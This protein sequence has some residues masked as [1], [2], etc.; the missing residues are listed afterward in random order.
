MNL[1]YILAA[2]IR[3]LFPETE[4]GQVVAT[5]ECF[6]CDVHFS[7]NFNSAMLSQLEERMRA[8]ACKEISL[9]ELTM[10]PTNAAQ[11]LEHHGDKKLA[12]KVRQEE[13]EVVLVQLDRFFF[14]SDG[15]VRIEKKPFFKLVCFWPH[16]QGVRILGVTAS[17]KEELKEQAQ[18]IK[19][20]QNP[21]HL[22]EE[23]K[24]VS[25]L[26]GGLVWEPRAEKFKELLQ[27]KII[28]IYSG[29]DHV[30]LP[31]GDEKKL[32]IE[33]I[34]K[35][36][37]G[38]VRFQI[39]KITSKE[40]WDSS[41]AHSDQAWGK[42]ED[43]AGLNSYLHLIAKFLTIFNFDYEKV[44][45][46]SRFEFRVKDRLG[47]FWTLSTLEWN[48]KTTLVQMSL[49]VSF[50]RCLGLLADSNETLM[51]RLKQLEN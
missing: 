24:C 44:V 30:C 9:K 31:E 29:F 22:L 36:K 4:V 50:E 1:A 47:R 16:K 3:E 11:M 48:R 7:E 17:S 5:G 10:L 20:L 19:A 35:R 27:K 14:L 33:W 37:R 34:A 18:R 43:E 46:Q 15:F 49:C 28:E 45:K 38:G 39:K 2:S 42:A 32:L 23:Q 41:V 40:A 13:G 51:N 8:W 12:Q 21:Q 25:W 26:G 6:F